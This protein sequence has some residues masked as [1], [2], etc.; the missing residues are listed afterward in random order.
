MWTKY[1]THQAVRALGPEIIRCSNP[2]PSYPFSA[3]PQVYFLRDERAY[4]PDCA[5]LYPVSPGVV[6]NGVTQCPS[7][8]GP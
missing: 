2:V 4:K 7:G 1:P 8:R 5:L 6:L 3:F